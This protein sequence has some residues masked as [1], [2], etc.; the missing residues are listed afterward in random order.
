MVFQWIVSDRLAGKLDW[1]EFLVLSD[2]IIFGV[3]VYWI[4]FKRVCFDT[5]GNATD[6]SKDTSNFFE[7]SQSLASYKSTH[8]ERNMQIKE[9]RR[10]WNPSNLQ[11]ILLTNPLK[12]PNAL[13]SKRSRNFPNNTPHNP[14]M[15]ERNTVINSSNSHPTIPSSLS[16]FS[17]WKGQA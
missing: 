7:Y 15:L 8:N 14:K 12:D 5:E 3:I 11:S 10:Q 9:P 13:K 4:R 2:R 1:C 17:V 16:S 6:E